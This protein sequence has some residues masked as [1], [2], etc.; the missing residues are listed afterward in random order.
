[1][2][3]RKL[4]PIWSMLDMLSEL[5][6]LRELEAPLFFAKFAP[7]NSVRV[8]RILPLVLEIEEEMG[9]D[10]PTFNNV[11]ILD[12]SGLLLQSERLI[13]FSTVYPNIR[14][15]KARILFQSDVSSLLNFISVT[16][17]L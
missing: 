7:K 2:R 16:N 14:S 3:A 6:H 5:P 13:A 1:M 17:Q 4:Y 10:C 8:I 11:D 12:L 15:L 9:R